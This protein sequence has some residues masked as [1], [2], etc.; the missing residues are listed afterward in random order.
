MQFRQDLDGNT[1]VVGDYVPTEPFSPVSSREAA[2]YIAQ[3]C[4]ELMGLAVNSGHGFL[5]YLLE[6]AH[7]EAGLHAAVH[8]RTPLEMHGELPPPKR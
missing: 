6:V 3:M 8:E 4:G 2:E 1:H 5:A 7:E